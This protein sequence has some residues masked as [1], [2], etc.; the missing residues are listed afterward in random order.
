MSIQ[1][2][3]EQRA[4]KA[5]ALHELVNKKDWKP[6]AD[7]PVYDA[8]LAEIDQIDAQIRNIETVN[9]RLADEA[10]KSGIVDAA[11]APA[12][13]RSPQRSGVLRQVAAQRLRR[14]LRRRPR[15]LQH[16]V[17]H[18]QQ[19]GRLHRPDRGGPRGA[20]RPEGLRRDALRG[21]RHPDHRR[22]RPATTR[23]RTAPRKP[24]RSS[25]RTPRPPADVSFGVKTLTVYKY[26]SKIV[27]VPFELLQDSNVDIEA[28]VRSSAW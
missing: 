12:R 1:A 7:Q 10:L 23:P 18:H 22:R 5:K 15:H 2:L 8:G 13:T 27:A 9:K 14:P 21:Q 19:P 25:A 20:G 28:F 6:E 16:H 4:A 24:A 17:H 26:S 3:R 11:C